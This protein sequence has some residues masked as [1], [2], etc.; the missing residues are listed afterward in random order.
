MSLTKFE[1]NH[2]LLQEPL[3]SD[4]NDVS[5][6]SLTSTTSSLSSITSASLLKKAFEC[7][8]SSSSKNSPLGSGGMPKSGTYRKLGS[9][10]IST[11][12]MVCSMYHTATTTLS[13]LRMDILTGVC[14]MMFCFGCGLCFIYDAFLKHTIFYC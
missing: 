7:K 13:Q 9:N 14:D 11:V 6:L 5:G 2:P 1:I 10:E 8:L 4:S 12:A 3:I